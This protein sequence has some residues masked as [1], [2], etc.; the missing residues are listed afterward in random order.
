MRARK[1]MRKGVTK[2][3]VEGI[4]IEERSVM[5]RKRNTKMLLRIILDLLIRKSRKAMGQASSSSRMPRATWSMILVPSKSVTFP[6][7]SSL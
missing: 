1:K 6:H 3:L 2:R 7:S 4:L 5:G